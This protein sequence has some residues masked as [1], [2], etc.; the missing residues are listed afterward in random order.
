LITQRSEFFRISRLPQW[1]QPGEPTTLLDDEPNVF[2]LYMHCLY[3]GTYDLGK[4]IDTDIAEAWN[5]EK[6]GIFSITLKSNAV[7]KQGLTMDLYI[8]LY[9]LA[10]KLLDPSTSNLVI[11]QLIV[12]S[13]KHRES[14]KID[15]V[16]L[17][18][19]Y[20]STT[21][22]SPLRKI[23]RDWLLSNDWVMQLPQGDCANLPLELLRDLITETSRLHKA[24]PHHRVHEVFRDLTISRPKGFYHQKVDQKPR[25]V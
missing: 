22:G 15:P 25:N 3:F 20:D 19:I 9:I 18:K 2:S 1:K 10:D 6:D 17:A 21:D 11:N 4:R 23:V 8:N 5:T 24:H 7:L 14:C 16:T 12:F 13:R